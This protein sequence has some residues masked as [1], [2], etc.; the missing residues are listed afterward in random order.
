MLIR[1]FKQSYL[2]QFL[3]LFFIQL[4]LWGKYLFSPQDTG[5]FI[6]IHPL[7]N[8]SLNLIDENPWVMTFIAFCLLALAAIL[9]NVIMIRNEL[10]PNN[11]LIPALVFITLMSHAPSL[12]TLYPELIAIVFI[13]LS[14]DR[15]M[16]CFGESDILVI[17]NILSAS[18]LISLA[19]L[20]YL[21]AIIFI[22]LIWIS[23]FIFRQLS[24]RIWAI[25]FIG[26]SLPYTYYIAYNYIFDKP[27]D[28]YI[29]WLRFF[30]DIKP[31]TID[32]PDPTYVIWGLITVFAIIAIF[33]TLTHLNERNV[34]IR[35]KVMVIVWLFIISLPISL[36]GHADF[37]A[38]QSFLFIP[39]AIFISGYM[40]TVKTKKWHELIFILYLVLI[41]LNNHL[42]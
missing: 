1:F 30:I 11:S 9:I 12:L 29:T 7:Y 34:N 36:F 26:L 33:H 19:S 18:I 37:L 32:Y 5:I 15:I 24:I 21:P 23:M 41:L 10:A 28:I 40:G 4:I 22:L 8:L 39:L 25:S 16:Q 2:Q 35:R 17:N 31:I 42:Y 13:L 27:Q 6:R 3:A 14:I 20:S 38:S